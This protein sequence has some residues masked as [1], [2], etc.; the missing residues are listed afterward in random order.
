MFS[1][2][3]LIK[4]ITNVIIMKSNLYQEEGHIYC[5]FKYS[6]LKKLFQDILSKNQV[7]SF[8]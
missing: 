8:Y 3:V 5:T 2:K 1:R 7:L 4:M 6:I